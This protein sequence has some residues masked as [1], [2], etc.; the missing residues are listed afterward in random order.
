MDPQTPVHNAITAEDHEFIPKA[1]DLLEYISEKQSRWGDEKQVLNTSQNR[2]RVIFSFLGYDY[3][4]WVQEKEEVLR[5]L[6]EDIKQ[7]K[8]GGEDA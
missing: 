6:Q 7:I 1:L 2:L 3:D 5:A 8:K 4:A